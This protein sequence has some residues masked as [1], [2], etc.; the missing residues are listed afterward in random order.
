MTMTSI[1][2][3]ERVWNPTTGCDRISPGCAHCYARTIA[4]RFWATQY[5]PNSDGSPR[6]F[7]DVRVHEDR[8][9]EPLSWRKPSR[10][11]VN[12]MSDLFHEAVPDEFIDKVFA[13][14]A[15]SGEHTFQILTKRPAR[16][17]SYLTQRNEP[18]DALRL[19]IRISRAVV[20]LTKHK[21]PP[22][23]RRESDWDEHLDFV[24][25]YT[26][27]KETFVLPNI[28]LGASV[29]DQQRADERIPLLLQTPAAI[30]FL[31]C[32]PLLGPVDLTKCGPMFEKL[33]RLQSHQEAIDAGVFEVRRP[34]DW[35]IVGGE[36]GPRA[37]P[38]HVE[39][40]ADIVKQCRAASVP[41]FCKQMG[42]VPYVR[43]ARLRHWEWREIHWPEDQRFSDA[44]DD[45]L[46]WRVHLADQK[47]GDPE[48]WPAD[49]RVREFPR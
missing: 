27:R 15:L 11:F 28:W 35:V 23:W 9:L 22:R 48:E 13:V 36:S 37:R 47:G 10:V 24:A 14:M 29:E 1:E 31:S 12:S 39:W 41:V 32:E 25:E 7:E 40:I 6:T 18:E 26:W 30:R 2:W 20:E 4:G 44:P 43:A 19:G 38:C 5:Q 21:G 49:L 34:L 42:S 16:M 33:N 17:L 3:T 8:L 46:G 45:P